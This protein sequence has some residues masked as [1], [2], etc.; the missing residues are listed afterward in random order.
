MHL[1]ESNVPS[2]NCYKVS[3][4][5]SLL[6]LPFQTTELD[7]LAKPSETRSLEYLATNPNGRVPALLLDD[8]ERTVLVE[9]NAIL[10]YLAEGTKYLPTRKLGRARVL[11]WM[12]FEQYSHEPYVAVFKWCTYWGGFDGRSPGEVEKLKTRGQDAIDIMEAHLEGK[13]FF[14]DETFTIADIALY[15]Y[16]QSAEPLGY[17]VGPNVKSWFERVRKQE[18]YVDIRKDPF[19]KAP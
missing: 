17:R 13:Q 15:V 7:I 1:Y 6:G 19:G 5:L 2:G 11:Q 12:F 14:V 3:L 8:A 16:T 10:F 9:S 18:G 4:M